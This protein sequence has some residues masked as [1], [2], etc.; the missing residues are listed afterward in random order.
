MSA[1]I[2]GPYT[3][4]IPNAGT[5]SPALRT[6]LSAGQLKVIFGTCTVFIVTC[7]AAALTAG[8]T[9][10]VLP[11][12]GGSTWTTLQNPSNS[13]V[14]IGALKSVPFPYS[15][16]RDLRIHSSSAEAAQR[17]FNLTFQLATTQ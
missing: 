5:D 14:T 3:L 13:D 4:S 6:I 1:H 17:D 15:G 12:E 11:V 10:S 9:V 16:F 7:L 2:A 8:V